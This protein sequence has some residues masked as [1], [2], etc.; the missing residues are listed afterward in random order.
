[1]FKRKS[2]LYILL[3]T[4]FLV[5]AV[6]IPVS[7]ATYKNIYGKTI[8]TRTGMEYNTPTF[9]LNSDKLKYSFWRNTS[10]PYSTSIALQ[11][12]KNN[13][14]NSKAWASTSGS[15]TKKGN[16]TNLETGLNYRIIITTTDPSSKSFSMFL[17]EVYE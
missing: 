6:F 16:F 5:G 13:K 10:G 2:G 1:M 11:V 9:V 8:S 14:W 15:T 7:A 4:L 12:Y 3:L 17:D